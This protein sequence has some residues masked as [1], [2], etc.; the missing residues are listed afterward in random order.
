MAFLAKSI[1]PQKVCEWQSEKRNP[2]KPDFL[3]EQAN[4]YGNI[5][6]FKLPILKG[7]SITGKH[8]RETFSAEIQSYIS[9]TRVYKTYFEDPNNRRW[10]ES[11]YNFKIYNPKRILVVGRRW[12]F[13]QDEW[14]EIISEYPN[15]EIMTYDDLID[16]I[17]AQFY[18]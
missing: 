17:I 4:G 1:H 2:I 15:L 18:N 5:V 13:E 9:Q 11:H 14:R 8:N 16:G 7:N 12:D 3:I 10:F 6:E